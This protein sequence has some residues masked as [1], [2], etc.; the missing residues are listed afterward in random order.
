MTYFRNNIFSLAIIVMVLTLFS[1][2]AEEQVDMPAGKLHLSIGQVSSDLQTRAIP[3]EL[4][5][6]LAENFNVRVQRKGSSYVAYDGK[7]VESINARIGVYNVTA[8]YGEDVLIGKDAPYYCGSAEV[9]VKKDQSSSVSIPCG[10]GNALVSVKFGIDEEERARFER[11][12]SDFGV[13]VRN[14]DY[15]M[16]IG[17]DETATSIYFPAGTSP[18]LL[19]FGTLKDD[20]TRTVSVA[21]THDELPEVFEAADHAK[22]TITLPDPES[23]V[24]VSIGKVELSEARLDE[25]IPLSW[26][27]VPTVTPVHNFGTSDMLVGTDLNFSN[28][29]PEMTWEARV[30]NE[31]GDTVRVIVGSGALVSDYKSSADWAYLSAGKYKATYFLHTDGEVAKVSS[32]EFMVPEPK[33]AIT[34]AGYT[35]HSL[36]E[37]GKIDEA[38]AADGFTLYEPSVSVNISPTLLSSGKFDYKFEYAFDGAITSA[39][40]NYVNIGN[41]TL[42]VRTEPYELSADITF[43]GTRVQSTAKFRITGIPFLFAPPTTATW[44]KTGKVNDDD[45]YARFGYM[46]DG[47]QTFRYKNVA[48]PAGTRLALDYKFI[49]TGDRAN[50]FSI[51][52]GEQVMIQ[53]EEVSGYDKPTYEG[54]EPVTISSAVTYIKCVNSYGAGLSYTDLYRV[55]LSYRQ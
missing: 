40:G 36:Y 48:I 26:L 20:T 15:A 23:V 10:V 7:F 51:S 5:K 29:Y 44:E 12:Y 31:N 49:P 42:T 34:F 54:I 43:D 50:T 38:N 46:S 27:P 53:S 39:E 37:E 17:K 24:V 21:L 9:E 2:C 47:S 14:G 28:A 41:K 25:T 45:G 3:A 22:L 16:S 6:P 52:A 19:F 30:S 35:S 8:S 1:A 13:M 11:F 18:E 32:R 55:G 33:L 4:P